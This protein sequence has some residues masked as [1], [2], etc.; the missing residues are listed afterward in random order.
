MSHRSGETCNG[1]N[2]RNCCCDFSSRPRSGSMKEFAT[3]CLKPGIYRIFD[4]GEPHETVRAGRT[5]TAAGGLRQRVY[6]NHLMGDQKG[7]LR[8]QL[9]AG[10]VCADLE[11]AKRLIAN[12]L[13]SRSTMRSRSNSRA[14]ETC[15]SKPI[16]TR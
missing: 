9:V 7:N 3:P 11:G 8:A 5:K 2:L 15:C 12:A 14:I 4:V 10:G 6:Q 13:T 16:G 1:E